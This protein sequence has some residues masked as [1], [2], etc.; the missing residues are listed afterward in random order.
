MEDIPNLV[1]IDCYC[2]ELSEITGIKLPII[3]RIVVKNF[4]IIY[5]T[6]AVSFIDATDNIETELNRM[7][8]GQNQKKLTIAV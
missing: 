6:E 5:R 2:K 3:K 4:A 7:L 8:E 1:D